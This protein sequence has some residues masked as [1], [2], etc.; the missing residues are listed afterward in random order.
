MEPQYHPSQTVRDVE[1]R[2]Y[3]VAFLEAIAGELVGVENSR[4]LDLV[5]AL[6]TAP[7]YELYCT[8]PAQ[9][10]VYLHAA[11]RLVAWLEYLET[12]PTRV[13][14]PEDTPPPGRYEFFWPQYIRPSFSEIEEYTLTGRSLAEEYRE[15]IA[16]RETFPQVVFMLIRT[17]CAY[18]NRTIP[19]AT[20]PV[21]HRPARN[22]GRYALPKPT[23]EDHS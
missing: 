8:D 23:Q 15:G 10:T 19:D 4:S 14:D 11:Q 20:R 17:L 18:L 13:Q 2:A 12:W 16:Y 1:G 5:L 7:A 6:E 22:P 3:Q 21:V 9:Y